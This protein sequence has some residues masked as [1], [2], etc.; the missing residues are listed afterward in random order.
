MKCKNCKT[1]L[2]SNQKFCPE[3]CAE[4]K[5]KKMSKKERA[6]ITCV[7][8]LVLIISGTIGGLFFYKN[9]SPNISDSDSNY[10][11]FEAGFTDV[12]VTDKKSAL[13]AIA[14][15]ADVIGI[16]NAQ[17]ELQCEYENSVRDSRYYRFQQY[18]N[19]IPVYGKT[20]SLAVNNNE[21]SA[22]VS[23]Y[24]PIDIEL[25]YNI[26]EK[27]AK[28]L[29]KEEFS[30]D[31]TDIISYGKYIYEQENSYMFLTPIKT[32][33]DNWIVGIAFVSGKNKSVKT[34]STTYYSNSIEYNQRLNG[35]KDEQY[36][37]VYRNN[38]SYYL[39]DTNRQ[40]YG[41]ET[42]SDNYWLL[43][44]KV[45]DAK[46]ISWNKSET[47]NKPSAVDAVANVKKSY[48][49][50]DLEHNY[51]SPNGNG[52]CIINVV[53]GFGFS[54]DNKYMYDNASSGSHIDEDGNNYTQINIG[55]KI[56]SEK[57][58]MSAYLDVIAHE[59]THAVVYYTAMLGGNRASE[60]LNEAYSDI[61]GEV[62]ENYTTNKNDWIIGNSIRN[63]P[64]TK[65]KSISKYNDK[66]DAHEN[67]QIIDYVAYLMNN[68]CDGSKTTI[69]MKSLGELW[70]NSLFLL[71][72]DASF[73]QCRNAVELSAR[74]ML[75]NN[76]L[77][78]E[79]YR[80]VVTAFDTVGIDNS[81]YSYKYKVK[82]DFDLKVL[83]SQKTDNVNFNLKIYKPSGT[84]LFN[85][86]DS[87]KKSELVLK[88]NSLYG[89]K[90]I[91]LDDGVYLLEI[92]DLDKNNV[93]SK[94]IITKII[95][96]GNSEN[97][98][99]EVTVYTDFSDITTVV[100]NKDEKDENL[101]LIPG[102]Y[103]F[104]SGAGAW[105]TELNIND[106]FTFSGMYHDSELGLIGE[107][108]PNGTVII[109]E[110]TGEFSKPEKVD[111]Y[112]YKLP[113]K[114][115][116][117]KNE[118]GY[119]YYDDGI[120]YE[121]VGEP[122]GFDGCREFYLYIKGRQTSDL[123]EEFLG[124]IYDY[125]ENAGKLLY[126]CIRNPQTD[127]CFVKNES[128][129][130]NISLEK[131]IPLIKEAI[132]SQKSAYG[133]GYGAL[134]DIDGNGIN[135]LI[136]VYTQITNNFPCKVCSVYTLVNDSVV[137]LIDKKEL[138]VEA[139]GPSGSLRIVKQGDKVYI[140]ITSENGETGGESIHRGGSWELF[141]FEGESVKCDVNV[142][143]EYAS[144]WN[145]DKKENEVEYSKSSATKNGKKINFYEYEDWRDNLETLLVI[146]AYDN[147]DDTEFENVMTLTDLLSFLT[148]KSTK[149]TLDDTVRYSVSWQES[150]KVTL[151]D[152][153][154]NNK[155]Q[156]ALYD[157]DKNGI[158]ELILRKD[159]SKYSIYTYDKNKVVYIGDEYWFYENGLYCHDKGLA[160]YDGGMGRL[161][162][163]YVY[164]YVLCDSKL[165]RKEKIISTESSSFEELYEL[166]K[167]YKQIPFVQISD[168]SL[169]DSNNN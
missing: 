150:Y 88:E 109:C 103:V 3:C 51:K 75:K 92:T 147:L 68:G 53:D 156:Y 65:M 155:C 49:Y 143:Y 38:N 8:C 145:D 80:T 94:P 118:D 2:K 21:V 15:V 117:L 6:L 162:I 16:Y 76:Q 25:E 50:Y 89:N 78:E 129:E 24:E 36:F 115:I 167:T 60:S 104:S 32:Y 46:P 96:D 151:K 168:M 19:D 77:S 47:L 122:Y 79:Q 98:V 160:V 85:I 165:V 157:I 95:V 7:C 146:N 125:N 136:M 39:N 29:L 100:L 121:C 137:S 66:K 55:K 23:N 54:N 14:S 10:I 90:Q 110:F 58:T 41:Y 114:S 13:E 91:H 127:V 31:D 161:H 105:S 87:V 158:P 81:A 72:S 37:D 140:A 48:D 56:V 148:D 42:E 9:N 128:D 11:A 141:S 164:L 34:L 108:N 18:Y 163:E 107:K 70:F 4:V 40:I 138:F 99:D 59:Y 166:L 57:Y 134:Y 102:K 169:F 152:Y 130:E 74:M 83:S 52:T 61:M 28:Q 111:N 67:A 33:D 106:D 135:E 27:E 22:L 43:F 82:N 133:D 63:I 139:G 84:A 62:I 1:K 116:S 154:T 64:K 144:T 73:A 159:N 132:E 86:I 124:W 12:K 20:L 119:V 149:T 93:N 71:P 69:E 44:S 142:S 112:T 153:G 26:S 120:K 5:V 131:Y 113:V 101:A 123:S 30:V 17:D 45:K 126:N 35:Q 97:V